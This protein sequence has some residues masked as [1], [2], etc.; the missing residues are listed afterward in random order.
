M[1]NSDPAIHNTAR[2]PRVHPSHLP[3]RVSA[4]RVP[5]TATKRTANG[6]MKP[7]RTTS[8]ITAARYPQHA[9]GLAAIV[10]LRTHVTEVATDAQ[11]VDLRSGLIV[12]A[13]VPGFDNDAQA[14]TMRCSCQA[15]RHVWHGSWAEATTGS[16]R[17]R[18][19]ATCT[20][21]SRSLG[22]TPGP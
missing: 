4:L 20:P 8:N 11:A 17:R 1:A 16:V 9:G 3:N 6:R 15:S 21:R 13:F 22:S 18:S 19:H 12:A 2:T 7:T 14:C 5:R 10:L